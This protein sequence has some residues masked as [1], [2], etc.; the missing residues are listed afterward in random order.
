MNCPV[1]SA[2]S[3]E[4]ITTDLTAAADALL[5]SSWF[6]SGT[7]AEIPTRATLRHEI[8]EPPKSLSLKL[9]P[10][11]TR[12]SSFTFA[13]THTSSVHPS[14]APAPARPLSLSP[15]PDQSTATTSEKKP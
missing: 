2:M 3:L 8:A 12:I 6:T 15:A 7:D 4:V 10:T 13:D 1:D 9:G 5:H 11:P 14:I